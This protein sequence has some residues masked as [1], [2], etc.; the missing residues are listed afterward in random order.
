MSTKNLEDESGSLAPLSAEEWRYAS[1][2]N[3]HVGSLTPLLEGKPHYH[4]FVKQMLTEA[5]LK[6]LDPWRIYRVA[7][8]LPPSIAARMPAWDDVKPVA[9][10]S[11]PSERHN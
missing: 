3:T 2:I 5:Y 9:P 8:I 10:A 11:E 6:G 1:M 7:A 4:A